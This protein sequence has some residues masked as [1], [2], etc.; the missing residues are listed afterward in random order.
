MAR[1]GIRMS[2]LLWVFVAFILGFAAVLFRLVDLQVLERETL[3]EEGERI[4]TKFELIEARRGNIRDRN[5]NLL[6]TS[7]TVRQVGVDPESIDPE[8]KSK[9]HNLAKLL[10]I[11]YSEVYQ[12]MKGGSR[13]VEGKVVPIR[14]N[15]L[16]DDVEERTYREI[17]KL[18]IKGVY[19]NRHFK[20]VYPNETLAAHIL[21]YVNKEETAVAGVEKEMNFYLEGQTGWLETEWDGK[22]QEMAQFRKRQV[23]PT[24]G[25]HVSLTI[26][27]MVQ[28]VIELELKKIA[29]YDPDGATIIVSDPATGSI[30]GLA[31]WPTYDPNEYFNTVKYPVAYQ[32]NLA[33]SDIY[34]PGSTFKVVPVGAALSEELVSPSTTFNCSLDRIPYQGRIVRLPDDHGEDLG[35]L[36]VEDIIARS[37]NRG[38]ANI[39]I[40]LGEDKLY[41]Y[42]HAFGFGEKTGVLLGPEREG[43]LHEPK[44]WDGLTISRL[45]MGHAIAVTPLQAH[46]AMSVLAN[47]GVL[48]KPQ[49]LSQVEDAEGNIIAEYEPKA[50]RRVISSSAA[51]VLSRMLVKT[52]SP[53]GTAP[54]AQIPGMEVAGKTGTAQR[55]KPSGGYSHS[56]VDASFIGYFPASDPR[57]VI[58]VVIYNPQKG[59]RY[60]GHL[61][62][63]AFKSVAEQLIHHLGISPKAPIR[64]F[65]AGLEEKE[66]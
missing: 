5:Q 56:E 47:D 10:E 30:L 13:K 4:R 7:L 46:F 27:M 6:A 3:A 25:F 49:I 8:D 2:R 12:K 54:Q 48:M 62:G 60:G 63:P 39:G 21:G 15:V 29:E 16:K 1:G 19:G 41:Q 9:W 32:R 31:N 11:P 26:D 33:I 37:S 43:I 23:D 64:G 17:L 42:A 51:R 34:E 28:H 55:I 22:R 52:V 57:L 45:P 66:E 18:E 20:R 14:W 59:I 40:L 65:I 53:E 58:S 38:A 24:D 61:A 50:I 35:T 36:T 44:D